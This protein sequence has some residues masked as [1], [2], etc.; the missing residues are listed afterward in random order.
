MN[1]L[2]SFLA[3]WLAE[4]LE[5]QLHSGAVHVKWNGP[6]EFILASHLPHIHSFDTKAELAGLLICEKCKGAFMVT[7]DGT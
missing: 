2:K 5:V 7:K 1:D 4:K 3:S 6:P